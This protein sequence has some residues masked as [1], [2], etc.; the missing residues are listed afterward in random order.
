MTNRDEDVNLEAEDVM[1]CC[2]LTD[3]QEAGI[4]VCGDGGTEDTA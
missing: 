3:F 1:I 4:C 2:Q